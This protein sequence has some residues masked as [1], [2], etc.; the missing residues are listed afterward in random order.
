MHAGM[1]P[2]VCQFKSVLQVWAA[3]LALQLLFEGVGKKNG[4]VGVWE[5]FYTTG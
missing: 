5:H 4:K 1:A 2:V 3:Q